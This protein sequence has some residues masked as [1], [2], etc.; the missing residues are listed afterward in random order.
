MNE[1]PYKNIE[2]VRQE[3]TNE[4]KSLLSDTKSIFHDS[5]NEI[6]LPEV[7]HIDIS[8]WSSR[9]FDSTPGPHA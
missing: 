6:A 1:S 8:V 2:S 5:E 7:Q 3:L 9:R 4:L